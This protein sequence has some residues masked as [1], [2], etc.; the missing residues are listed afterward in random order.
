MSVMQEITRIK[1]KIVL[2]G[3]PAVGKTSL[4][5]RY[6]EDKFS[7]NYLMTIGFKVTSKRLMI[8]DETSGSNIEL[9]LMIWDVMGQKG[10]DMTPERAFMGAKGGIIVCDRTRVDTLN[11]IP[12]LVTKLFNITTDI[13]LLF[14]ANK[15]DLVE[16]FQF[17]DKALLE[18]VLPYNA[19]YL[20]TSAKTGQNVEMAFQII[21]K[22][23]LR[24]QGAIS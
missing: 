16:Q 3:N 6:V 18:Q 12:D 9:T 17:D 24:E 14:L 1:R 2:V 4:I 15:N 5:R 13:P 21:G 7:D 8:M 20:L 23:L 11:D 10:F 22:N 19:P